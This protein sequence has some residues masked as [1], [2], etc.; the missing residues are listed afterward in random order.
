MNTLLTL[1]FAEN[2]GR[3]TA[4]LRP[5]VLQLLSAIRIGNRTSKRFLMHHACHR[6]PRALIMVRVHYRPYRHS[7]PAGSVASGSAIAGAVYCTCWITTDRSQQ[8]GRWRYHYQSGNK[9]HRGAV[10]A[11]LQNK[12]IRCSAS[13]AAGTLTLGLPGLIGAW[14][15]TR[16]QTSSARSMATLLPTL[17]RLPDLTGCSPG[18]SRQQDVDNIFGNG[19]SY[20]GENLI[21]GNQFLDGEQHLRGRRRSLER[22]YWQPTAGWVLRWLC[23]ANGTTRGH[24]GGIATRTQST[25]KII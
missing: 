6:S 17:L 23:H 5:I 14:R 7:F 24:A 8:R 21:A 1:D 25:N 3:T 15:S 2:T 12:I 9:P 13:V 10:L 16:S 18:G 11:V 4:D 22:Y 20:N 19:T